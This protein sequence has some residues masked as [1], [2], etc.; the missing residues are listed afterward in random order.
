M[1]FADFAIGIDIGD[2]DGAGHKIKVLKDEDPS[3]KVRAATTMSL[4]AITS[5][6]NKLVTIEEYFHSNNKSDNAWNTD[7]REDL[8]LPK[9]ADRLIEYIIRWMKAYE[10]SGTILMKGMI[11]VY[12]DSAS[13]GFRDLLDMSARKYGVFNLRFIGSTKISIQSRVDFYRLLMSMNDFI[14]SDKCKNLKREIKACRR[15]KKGEAREDGNEHLLN[16]HE[17]GATPLL[18]S[19][20]RWKTFKQH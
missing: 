9:Q 17:Y 15:G 14:I 1:T 12:V 5:D 2:S 18:S 4:V 3:K 19:L 7:D 10:D 6:L 11:N 13:P 20:K 8:S 16:A